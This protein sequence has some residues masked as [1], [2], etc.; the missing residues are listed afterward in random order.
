MTDQNPLIV[1]TPSG[2]R[3]RFALGTPVLQAARALGWNALQFSHAAQ[4]EAVMTERGWWSRP[5][6]TPG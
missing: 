2:K 4:A 3:G 1:F 6:V 5:D